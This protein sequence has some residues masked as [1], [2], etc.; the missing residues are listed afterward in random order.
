MTV[1]VRTAASRRL[2]A[3]DRGGSGPRPEAVVFSPDGLRIAFMASVPPAGTQTK[4]NQIF[5]VDA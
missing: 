2:T 5:V 1:D 4:T 3:P